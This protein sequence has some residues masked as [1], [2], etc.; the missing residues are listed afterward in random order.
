[1]MMLSGADI[2]NLFGT[3]DSA[4]PPPVNGSVLLKPFAS[5][6][7]AIDILARHPIPSLT[8]DEIFARLEDM[9][10]PPPVLQKAMPLFVTEGFVVATDTTN[11][12][13]DRR[14]PYTT[15]VRPDFQ[16]ALMHVPPQFFEDIRTWPFLLEVIENVQG[17]VRFV[18]QER[19][20]T[21]PGFNNYLKR[22]RRAGKD[23]NFTSWN[24][25]VN[26]LEGGASIDEVFE[27]DLA[28]LATLGAIVVPGPAA[29]LPARPTG[30]PAMKMT[31]N[32]QEQVVDILA[33]DAFDAGD[34]SDYFQGLILASRLPDAVKMDRSSQLRG[35]AELDARRLVSWAANYGTNPE[36][37]NDAV[38]S[39]VLPRMPKFGFE[40][41]ATLASIIVAYRLAPAAR[42]DELRIRYQIP[43][44]LAN[45]ALPPASGPAIDWVGPSDE[46]QLQSWLHPEPAFL[47]VALLQ[48]AVARARS[49]CRVEVAGIGERGTGVLIADDLVL[50]NYHVLT[51]R[52]EDLLSHA[53][54]T[55]LRFG[56]FTADGVGTP[57]TDGQVIKLHPTDPVVAASPVHE[58]D[59]VLLR[60]NGARAKDV[61][62]APLGALLPR[63][64]SALH[65]LQ[66]PQGGPM[67]LALSK[68]G[69]TTVDAG[70]GKIQYVTRSAGG[71]SGSP[72]FNEQWDLVAL[73]HAEV[74]QAFGSVREG[75]LMQSI[76]GRIQPFLQS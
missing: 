51:K 29:L 75:I 57:A 25:L 19:G 33:R 52:P 7:K 40:K 49:V 21:S 69:V 71:S 12:R 10:L 3:V 22:K 2:G 28:P 9:T 43:R 18:A 35:N 54:T 50:T 20:D 55:E 47:E 30:R 68:N 58:Y 5:V 16:L 31:A 64:D 38:A 66:H 73:H 8:S 32:D 59:F 48:N 26:F 13:G 65:I 37:G 15:A 53:K 27:I 1:M 42:L 45:A 6:A 14:R 41:A 44:S 39:L 76:L 60:T 11:F 74:A 62:P 70:S 63:A 34:I 36:D 46:I 72:C 4:P 17:S 61:V 67:M 24:F 23:W 56:A